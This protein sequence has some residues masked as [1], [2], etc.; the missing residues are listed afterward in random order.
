MIQEG[1]YSSAIFLEMPYFQKIWKKK[2]WV[3]VQCMQNQA[4]LGITKFLFLSYKFYL[5]D[6]SIDCKVKR[7][8]MKCSIFNFSFLQPLPLSRTTIYNI[9]FTFLIKYLLDNYNLSKT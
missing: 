4:A 9:M 5:E 7:I 8:F 6:M 2:I 3:F 1:S